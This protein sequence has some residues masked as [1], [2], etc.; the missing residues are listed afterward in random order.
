ML[1][2]CIPC[3]S[4]SSPAQRGNESKSYAVDSDGG[5][6]ISI[7]DDNM[8]RLD[9]PLPHRVTLEEVEASKGVLLTLVA[10]SW[11][12]LRRYW[13][14]SRAQNVLKIDAP[15]TVTL[16]GPETKLNG[17][18]ATISSYFSIEFNF[19][20]CDSQRYLHD[21]CEASSRAPSLALHLVIAAMALQM[22]KP[23][24]NSCTLTE[25]TDNTRIKSTMWLSG[26]LLHMQACQLELSE[27]QKLSAGVPIINISAEDSYVTALLLYHKQHAEE[28]S[29]SERLVSPQVAIMPSSTTDPHIPTV[30]ASQGN[31][32][33]TARSETLPIFNS[34]AM[35]DNVP[36]M[37]TLCSL[38][39][40]ILYQNKSSRLYF[41]KAFNKPLGLQTGH[42]GNSAMSG[43]QAKYCN[44]NSSTTP[45][46][47]SKP[48]AA[49]DG[50][51]GC[52]L[53]SEVAVQVLNM[54]TMTPRITPPQQ[55]EAAAAIKDQVAVA[56]GGTHDAPLQCDA[57]NSVETSSAAEANSSQKA[58]TRE[59]RSVV[60][61][62][63]PAWLTRMNNDVDMSES[64]A[65]EGSMVRYPSCN[66]ST[67]AVQ[68][69]MGALQVSRPHR[70]R[71]SLLSVVSEE[72]EPSSRPSSHVGL[73]V[74]AS[75]AA[76][77]FSGSADGFQDLNAS[78]DHSALT[79]LQSPHA[80]AGMSS[81]FVSEV[82]SVANGSS[83][84]LQNSNPLTQLGS[85]SPNVMPMADTTSP[86]SLTDLSTGPLAKFQKTISLLNLKR[87]KVL[88]RMNSGKQLRADK[89]QVTGK[90][91][92]RTLSAGTFVPSSRGERRASSGPNAWRPVDSTDSSRH[93]LF[94]TTS[95]LSSSSKNL[96]V[97]A[98]DIINLRSESE[99][100]ALP[101]T[102]AGR[103]HKSA[104]ASG[105][106]ASAGSGHQKIVG[107]GGRQD[108]AIPVGLLASDSNEQV[109]VSSGLNRSS[110]PVTGETAGATAAA[111]DD[112][113]CR[114]EDGGEDDELF[115]AVPVSVA[116]DADNA[117]SVPRLHSSSAASSA[118]KS[119][120]APLLLPHSSSIL[121]VTG[122]GMESSHSDLLESAGKGRR[123]A[124]TNLSLEVSSV[125]ALSS[126]DTLNHSSSLFAPPPSPLR[127]GPVLLAAPPSSA[128][129]MQH[130]LSLFAPPSTPFGPASAGIGLTDIFNLP[131]YPTSQVQDKTMMSNPQPDLDI[132]C[133]PQATFQ[134]QAPAG[135]MILHNIND[136]DAGKTRPRI[137]SWL[138]QAS[139]AVV[140][141]LTSL[142]SQ[143]RP[144]SSDSHL[145][146][147]L[148]SSVILQ[149]QQ[150]A[151]TMAAGAAGDYTLS[152]ISP[153]QMRIQRTSMDFPIQKIAATTGAVG[154]SSPFRALYRSSMEAPG[155]PS[156]FHALR[157]SPI[158][159]P[160]QNSPRLTPLS[161]LRSSSV[162]TSLP[163]ALL[164]PAGSS[165]RR[166]STVVHGSSEHVAFWH[167]VVLQLVPHPMPNA[168][169]GSN[170]ALLIVQTD[171][172][173]RMQ[174]ETALAD[175]SEGQLSLLSTIFPRH[176]VEHLSITGIS[177]LPLH[178]GSLARSHEDVTILFLDI[179]GFTAMSERVVPSNILVLLNQLFTM[180]DYLADHHKVHKIDTA[181][182]CYIAAGGITGAE[183]DEGGFYEVRKSAQ[184]AS[185]SALNVLNFA[186]DML[187][188]SRKVLMPHNG[189]PV[190]VRIGLHT[191]PCV[192][193]LVGTK[194][195]KFSLFGDTINTA[196]RM[197]S[198]CMEGCIQV[199]ASTHNLL[200]SCP[201][202]DI[203][204]WQPSGGM[205]IKGKGRMDTFIW[206]PEDE[207]GFY[208]APLPA[209]AQR[210][211]K[212][213]RGSSSGIEDNSLS[214]VSSADQFSSGSRKL[215]G[216]GSF[217]SE[218][219]D[220]HSSDNNLS[221]LMNPGLR[222]MIQDLHRRGLHALHSQGMMSDINMPSPPLSRGLSGSSAGRP[223]RFYMHGM[224]RSAGHHSRFQDTSYS[225]R[226]SDIIMLTGGLPSGVG[227]TGDLDTDGDIDI[228]SGSLYRNGVSSGGL[229]G[230]ITAALPS[231][232]GAEAYNTSRSMGGEDILRL[233]RCLSRKSSRSSN[234]SRGR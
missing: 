16:V 22:G 204:Q 31:L 189:Q 179:V 35:T 122:G 226:A 152:S 109:H 58:P 54:L 108:L 209:V 88:E 200:T 217:K 221:Q 5:D 104:A 144:L 91:T 107:S 126:A 196:S 9:G 233:S 227:L 156:P 76:V 24:S 51:L 95:R 17:E 230:S 14:D 37:F 185:H 174:M 206:R 115:V 55:A 65:M 166:S 66:I 59:W 141:P 101:S 149:H 198:T 138:S 50:L 160:P 173:A 202:F 205:D 29:E 188:C 112:G 75:S 127:S 27:G 155:Q 147:P 48:L 225:S 165:S 137:R 105:Y 145:R 93:P 3:F 143:Q 124:L 12:E 117:A 53:G 142:R 195:P 13:S 61:V 167:D 118:G 146:S 183:E 228:E 100:S 211:L 187:R 33:T 8:L 180:F 73:L 186:K 208:E 161:P 150:Q 163:Q 32:P 216:S 121:E 62:P 45:V 212:L 38:D 30:P 136:Q 106:D 57:S 153:L 84:L 110:S 164:L 194:V 158:E 60:R 213:V 67:S 135:V 97:H 120:L 94:G 157:R 41:G 181:G 71:A 123:P 86:L 80:T 49:P 103:R 177:S 111:E 148:N 82:I 170:M 42:R 77:P 190:T 139:S 11:E 125:T 25:R 203:A 70:R 201:G 89:Q 46:Y 134:A 39:G 119:P 176:V 64:F 220:D 218:C 133:S 231:M 98:A 162:G 96:Q 81:S 40:N 43:P 18:E 113:F 229:S 15:G 191:G 52:L 140:N 151:L 44:A 129:T 2:H 85:K 219:D 192:S 4:V 168:E 214:R 7:K 92:G 128:E 222:S 175:M 19:C 26:G 69:H 10:K 116:S 159:P 74:K 193:G 172:T 154:I 36:A 83:S 114:D 1:K 171:I 182:D 56:N 87:T 78:A 63:P 199:S 23:Y 99:T 215:Q 47:H 169:T 79:T 90:A 68:A 132:R 20:S 6:I 72:L 223:G 130:N 131:S 34:T 234:Q 178:F 207:E 224:A 102:H 232:M 184:D 28:A 210:V 21:L 197:E